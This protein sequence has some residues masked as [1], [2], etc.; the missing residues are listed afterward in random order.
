MMPGGTSP[1]RKRPRRSLS[2]S[3]AK[4]NA[5]KSIVL[6]FNNT[7]PAKLACPVCSQMVP[8]YDLNRHLD[9]MCASRDDVTP[10]APGLGGVPGSAVAPGEGVTPEKSPPS[11]TDLTPEQSDSATRGAQKRTSPYF[12]GTDG[13]VCHSQDTELRSRQVQVVPLGSLSS[14]LSRRYLQA[15]RA[16]EKNEASAAAVRVVASCAE[17]KDEDRGLE[18]SSQKENLFSCDSLP[19]QDPV[20]GPSLMAAAKPEPPQDRGRSTLAPA[21]PDNAVLSP[22]RTP[23]NKPLSA[24]E[25]SRAEQESVGQADGAG[26]GTREADVGEETEVPR[27]SES[28]TRLSWEAPSQSS[29]HDASEWGNFHKLP[30]EGDSGLKDETAPGVPSGL[31][32]SCGVPGEM[33]PAPPGHPYYLRSFLVVLG[34]VFENEDDR[35]LFDEQER[36]IVTKFH[37]LSERGQK[38]YVRLFQRKFGWIKRHKLEYE[39]IAPDLAPVVGELER[40]GFLQTESELQEL[41][42]VLELLSA[43]ELR[44]LAKTFR[45]GSPG[46]QKQQLAEALLKLARQPSVCTW[47][48]NAPGVGAVILKRAKDLAGP[49]LRVCRGPRAVFSRALLLFSPT[50]SPEEEDAACGGQGQ[51]SAVLLANLGRVA[52]PRYTVSRR[53]RVFQDRDDLLRY[54]AAAHVLSDISAAMAAGNWKEAN[55]LSQGARRDWKELK[56]HPSLR[57]HAALPPFLRCFT[58]GWVYTR[59]LSRAVEILQRLHLYEEAVQELEDL[60]SQK[61]YCPDSRGRWWDRLALNLHQHL[62]RLEPAIKCIAEGLA[63]PEVRTGHRLSLY[64]RA[65]RLRASP[66]CRRYRHLLQQLPEVTVQDVKHVSPVLWVLPR[67]GSQEPFGC[68]RLVDL[69]DWRALWTG[70]WPPL[71]PHPLAGLLRP[72][73][74][75]LPGNLRGQQLAAFAGVAFVV[76]APESSS[77]AHI[78]PGAE[79]VTWEVP[80][81]GSPASEWVAGGRVGLGVPR[82]APCSCSEA[83]GRPPVP[84]QVT[85]T[86]RLCPQ[87]GM[88]KS[89]FVLEAGGPATP[90]TVLCSVEELALD[91]YRRSGFDQGIHGEGS[92]FITLFGL[93]LWDIIFMDGIADVFRNA[94][95][96]FP[97]DLCTDSFFASRRPAIEARLRQIHAAPAE[98]LGAWVAATWEA[99]EGRA[100]SVVSWDRFASL[101]QAQDLVSCLGGP[102]LSGVCR[103]LAEDFRHCRGG[104]P[105]LVVWSSQDRRCKIYFAPVCAWILRSLTTVFS[106]AGVLNVDSG[107]VG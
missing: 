78:S 39:E 2:S 56:S 94:Y 55:A 28:E 16:T 62:K 50:D 32:P 65:V 79:A 107:A 18:S 25:D 9:D 20:E 34:A 17:A 40:A 63:D 24:S 42:E 64:Q 10:G 89:V 30:L 66:S 44:T 58:V 26:V 37:Q 7:P 61:V 54:A 35:M 59:I 73:V 98:R 102:V 90:A 14:K 88:G 96:A 38:L 77:G 21:S 29:T 70:A 22:Q 95:Q 76:R 23:G 86:G 33:G 69:G 92:T 53:A 83:H 82:F 103:R 104:L 93:L 74:E 91:H 12:Q 31:G 105:D 46:G 52:F 84:S 49:A 3:R 13:G 106:R 4:K 80:P 71:H 27:A 11:K 48:K 87:L 47:G 1:A 60:L 51:L 97:L 81:W 45:V 36:G 100:A 41:P 72:W 15:R 101:Q 85:I 8:R 99:Q 67:E 19:E 68:H 6:C 75:R 5:S 57:H 43:P